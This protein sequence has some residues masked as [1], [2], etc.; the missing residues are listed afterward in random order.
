[1]QRLERSPEDARTPRRTRWAG[2]ERPQLD[3]RTWP[4]RRA[5]RPLREHTELRRLL[6]NVTR[7][8][9]SLR[10]VS[11]LLRGVAAGWGA[12]KMG[13]GCLSTVIIFVVLWYLL[14]HFNI[15]R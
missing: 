7:T 1:M 9:V 8:R 2:Q 6:C 5:A 13:G 12:K 11:K 3:Q 14:G 4:R 15:F 10:F